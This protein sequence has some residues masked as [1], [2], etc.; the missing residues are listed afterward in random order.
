MPRTPIYLK[1]METKSE[2]NPVA[3][4][5]DAGLDARFISQTEMTFRQWREILD[6]TDLH[7]Q[8]GQDLTDLYA[9][10]YNADKRDQ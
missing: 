4:L 10:F 1:M 2:K 3:R 6:K 9:T 7:N 8:N 5:I